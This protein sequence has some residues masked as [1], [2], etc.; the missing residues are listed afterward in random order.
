VA[1]S[2]TASAQAWSYYLNIIALFHRT[3]SMFTN[4]SSETLCWDH[5]NIALEEICYNLK[6][7]PENK[8]ISCKNF[9]T[10]GANGGV[11]LLSTIEKDIKV[12]DNRREQMLVYLYG[13]KKEAVSGEIVHVDEDAVLVSLLSLFIY[14]NFLKLSCYEISVCICFV[15]PTK[16]RNFIIS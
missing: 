11:Y 3:C 2:N 4:G 6:Y 5:G 15:F 8:Q 7:L 14:L 12:D 13:I 1:A 9:E 16:I 10:A